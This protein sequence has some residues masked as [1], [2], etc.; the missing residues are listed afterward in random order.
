MLYNITSERRCNRSLTDDIRKIK[1][2]ALLPEKEMIKN[3]SY[4][5]FWVGLTFSNHLSCI[6][7]SLDELKCFVMFKSFT[8]WPNIS[9]FYCRGKQQ[10]A[11]WTS[12]NSVI[13]GNKSVSIHTSLA[14]AMKS[15]KTC[16]NH[17]LLLFSLITKHSLIIC[18]LTWPQHRFKSF[19]LCKVEKQNKYL[20]NLL[21]GVHNL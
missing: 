15:T 9:F 16:K 17:L 1:P 14:A 20:L 10:Q 7:T 3:S 2:N 6:K 13:G 21:L 5:T 18:H 12:F 4:I 11:D 8:L 19:P